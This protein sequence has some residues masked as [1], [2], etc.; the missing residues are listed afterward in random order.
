MADV[1]KRKRMIR[2]GRWAAPL[3]WRRRTR[4]DR[5]EPVRERA[6]KAQKWPLVEATQPY[7]VYKDR[8]GSLTAVK[9]ETPRIT[10]MIS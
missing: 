2:T 3:Y 6:S 7:D 4:I 8:F 1:P 10:A 9:A 5:I